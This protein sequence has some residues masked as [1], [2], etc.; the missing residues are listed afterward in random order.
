MMVLAKKEG[1]QLSRD[2]AIAQI[3]DDLEKIASVMDEAKEMAAVL[4]WIN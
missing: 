4:G 1:R 3:N 2:E